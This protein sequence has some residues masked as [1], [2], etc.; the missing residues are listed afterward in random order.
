[1][2]KKVFSFLRLKDRYHASLVCRHW[3]DVFYSPSIWRKL[4]M[5][6]TTFTHKRMTPFKGYWLELNNHKVLKWLQSVGSFLVTLQIEPI[7]DFYNLFAFIK[8]LNEFIESNREDISMDSLVNFYFTFA[9]ESRD[10]TEVSIYGTGGRLLQELARLLKNLKGLE[11]LKM[12]HLL[13]DLKD[14]P[15]VL[16]Y[17]VTNCGT[18]LRQVELRNFTKELYPLF[19]V[20]MFRNLH[21]VIISPQHLSND[22]VRG[23]I[24]SKVTNLHIVQ[25]QYSEEAYFID[26]DVWKAAAERMPVLNVHLSAR[27]ATPMDIMWQEGAPV[28][29]VLYT[30]KF[31]QVHSLA[32]DT[33]TVLY[34]TSLQVYGHLD[35]PRYHDSRSFTGRCDENLVNL[36]RTCSKIHTIIIRQKISTST[37]IILAREG[38]ALK[39]LFVR[40]NGII[41]RCD[42]QRTLTW[43]DDYYWTMRRAAHSYQETFDEVSRCLGYAWQPLTDKQFKELRSQYCNINCSTQGGFDTS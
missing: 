37:L 3:N 10:K 30:T 14:A 15:G 2:L 36:I 4:V 23:L 26:V 7:S 34:N 35:L 29:S 9:C 41:K 28:R 18:T 1:M 5:N 33:I 22:I 43:D 39:H 32:I 13:L 40:R 27:G 11:E 6:S 12:N 16:D 8:I 38:H 25:D 20:G 24:S 19:I 21:T 31:S 17:L 42:W